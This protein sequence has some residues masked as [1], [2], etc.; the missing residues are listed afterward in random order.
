M[1]FD[2]MAREMVDAYTRD[3][4]RT[5][6]VFSGECKIGWRK[7]AEHVV[8]LLRAG[9]KFDDDHLAQEAYYCYM[10]FIMEKPEDARE[11]T[12]LPQGQQ[13]AWRAGV[14]R[15]RELLREEQHE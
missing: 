11:F 9:S 7:A 14:R 10:T 8:G 5:W 6:E 13:D 3:G 2:T 1:D 12:K 15:L 4:W